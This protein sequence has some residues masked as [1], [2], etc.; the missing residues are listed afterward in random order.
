VIPATITKGAQTVSY[1]YSAT[2]QKIKNT[3]INT[4]GS[5]TTTVYNN[6]FVYIEGILKYI[7][8]SEGRVIV[9]GTNYK[10]EYWLK[11]HLGNTRVAFSDG[12]NNG[13]IESSEVTQVTDYYPFGMAHDNSKPD[14]AQKYLYNGKELQDVTDWYDYGARM[15]DAQLGRWHTL[16]PKADQYRRWSPYNYCMDNPLKFT[17]PDGMGPVM[18]GVPSKIDPA[19]GFATVAQSTTYIPQPSLPPLNNPSDPLTS[20]PSNSGTIS[21]AP[22]SLANWSNVM[23]DPESD[24][25]RLRRDRFKMSKDKGRKPGGIG[26]LCLLTPTP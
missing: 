21:P 4:N 2:G 6:N 16:D 14:A 9:N 8:T 18:G 7:L 1:N 25:S 10:Y 5:S 15:Y 26:V 12:N 19:T 24:R 20:P 13:T 17:D 11:D 22:P 23:I 3:I